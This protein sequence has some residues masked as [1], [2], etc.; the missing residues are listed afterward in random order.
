MISLLIII[1]NL[2]PNEISGK[3]FENKL[4]KL[5]LC[6]MET[7]KDNYIEILVKRCKGIS[8]MNLRRTSITN[9]S[10]ISIIKNLDNTLE[11]LNVNDNDIDFDKLIE[12]GSL[13][14]LKVLNCLFLY[15][16][17]E[18][19]K[20]RRQFPHLKIN[21]KTVSAAAPD[22][23]LQPKNGFWNINATQTNL[24]QDNIT[25]ESD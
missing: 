17:E 6:D 19:D 9:A 5:S 20:L 10:I 22:L 12:V 16:F 24:F 25:S 18:I 21:Q 7:V 14:K 2:I 1:C 8:L 13:P 11:E 23:Y 4:T 3:P 15:N